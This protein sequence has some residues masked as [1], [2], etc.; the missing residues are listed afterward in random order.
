MAATCNL[1]E[2]LDVPDVTVDATDNTSVPFRGAGYDDRRD[3]ARLTRQ[4]DCIA[5]VT[6]GG[7]WWTI[8][9][10]TTAC[11]KRYPAVGFPE[12][13]V[14]AQI[15]NLKKVGYGVERRNVAAGLFE[16]RVTPPTNP[17]IGR[18]LRDR[19]IAEETRRRMPAGWNSEATHAV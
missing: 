17:G 16:Y 8:A 18:A 5:A 10:L 11:R 4:V 7:E 9:K 2:A 6:V 3:R 14:S 13:S 19:Q 1:F 15:R 12:C